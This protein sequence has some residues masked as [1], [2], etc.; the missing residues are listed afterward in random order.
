MSSITYIDL[1]EALNN[2]SIPPWNG[3]GEKGFLHAYIEWQIWD[4]EQIIWIFS[5]QLHVTE[6]VWRSSRNGHYV[7]HIVN[8]VKDPVIFY[9]WKSYL[10]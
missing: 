9:E 3:Y 4:I 8:D 1:N 2:S 7:P 6:T 10:Q 5:L